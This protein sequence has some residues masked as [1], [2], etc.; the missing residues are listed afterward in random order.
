MKEI[1]NF[2]KKNELPEFS[3]KYYTDPFYQILSFDSSESR[4]SPFTF[5]GVDINFDNTIDSYT[6]S[7]DKYY[8]ITAYMLLCHN[9]I[10]IEVK[11]NDRMFTVDMTLQNFIDFLSN[12][13]STN[14]VS[15]ENLDSQTY[16]CVLYGI[17]FIEDKDN[18]NERN[19]QIYL[20]KWDERT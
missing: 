16:A 12:S 4:S 3:N 8:T 13:D 20:K 2:L 17:V 1:H 6:L 5:E 14:V 18:T 15:C 9:F 7:F 11:Y 19:I 10:G